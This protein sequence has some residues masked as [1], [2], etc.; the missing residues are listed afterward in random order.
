LIGKS[1]IK[2]LVYGWYHKG[3]VGDDLFEDAFHKL[4][5]EFEFIF[6]DEITEE[7]LSETDAV[8]F[9]GGSFLFSA[10]LIAENLLS[11]LK[12]KKIFYIGVG[13]ET[14]IHPVHQ[15]LIK[16]AKLVCIRSN[17]L[18]KI[19]KLNSNVMLISDL[20][21]FLQ[22]SSLVKESE[23]KTVLIFPNI[24]V[25]PSYKDT[26]W[27]HTSWL[28]FKSEFVQALENIINAG[29]DIKFLSMC[30]NSKMNDAWTAHEI[31]SHLDNRDRAIVVPTGNNFA[32]IAAEVSKHKIVITQRYHGIILSQ[33]LRK[34]CVSI[35]HHDKLKI[36]SIKEVQS[37]PYYGINKDE[38]L[39]K[40]YQLSQVNLSSNLSIDNNAF[41]VMQE[42]VRALL[43]NG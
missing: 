26:Y 18:E 43:Q 28:Y 10:P 27:K 3:N 2:A 38:L 13:A 17:D 37:I 6:T 14:D 39:N 40:F 12:K 5:P 30:N 33:L 21:Y 23:N 25:V 4:F 19:S 22:D 15:D 29:W 35:Y 41:V 20:V 11:K 32:E 8:F 24:S 31:I 7:L 34:P 36:S 16:I 9:G 42:K 1:S